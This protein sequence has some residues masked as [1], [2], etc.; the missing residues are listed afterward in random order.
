MPQSE[1]LVSSHGLAPHVLRDLIVLV[2]SES[3]GESLFALKAR[4]SRDPR[5]RAAWESLQRL[6]AQT[7]RGATAVLR[8]LGVTSIGHPAVASGAG[9][10]CAAGL[11][12][13]P[14]KAQMR[15][16]LAGTAPFLTSFH[17]LAAS[18]AGTAHA[19]FFDYVVAHEL[20]IA[21]FAEAE[22][23]DQRDSLALVRDLLERAASI[24][25]SELA[26]A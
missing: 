7:H 14:W 22:L 6:E 9:L 3:F 11:T 13:L 19:P 26:S 17:R 5:R 15:M 20:A 25:A 2:H 10:P 8:R 18:F 4:V 21:H 16:L 23:R 1:S 24:P 12:L